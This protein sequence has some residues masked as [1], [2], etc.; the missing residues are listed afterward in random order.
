MLLQP[1]GLLGKAAPL[2]HFLFSSQD[3]CNLVPTPWAACEQRAA[4]TQL[5][6]QFHKGPSRQVCRLPSAPETG[7]AAFQTP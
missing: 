1:Q 3:G 6:L 2:S 5:L 4:V 7:R